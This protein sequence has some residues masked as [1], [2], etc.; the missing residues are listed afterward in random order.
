M[1]LIETMWSFKSIFD[2]WGYETPSSDCISCTSSSFSQHNVFSP[3]L[4]CVHC[5]PLHLRFHL[6]LVVRWMIAEVQRHAMW[7]GVNVIR[8]VNTATAL[9]PGPW[10]WWSPTICQW[11]GGGVVTI[12]APRPTV[13]KLYQWK[14]CYSKGPISNFNTQEIHSFPKVFKV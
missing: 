13:T 9:H 7:C 3:L 8:G 10:C 14:W 12:P 11:L 2:C 1:P 6:H 5:E 4:L